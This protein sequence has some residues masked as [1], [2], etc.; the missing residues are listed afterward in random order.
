M[1]PPAFFSMKQRNHSPF[2]MSFIQTKESFA[3]KA[4][5]YS[6]KGFVFCLLS[7]LDGFLLKNCRA[8]IRREIDL[9][10]RNDKI[11]HPRHYFRRLSGLMAT[12]KSYMKEININKFLIRKHESSER[13]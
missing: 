3:E 2:Q 6:N 11:F 9:N 5:F 12:R 1:R 13:G 10:H 7:T 8:N 4:D